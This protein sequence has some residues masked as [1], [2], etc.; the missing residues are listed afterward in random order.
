MEINL[1]VTPLSTL[2]CDPSSCEVD[3]D[4]IFKKLGVVHPEPAIPMDMLLP[5]SDELDRPE[6]SERLAQRFGDPTRMGPTGTSSRIHHWLTSKHAP[7][8]ASPPSIDSCPGGPPP[9]C[10]AAHRTPHIVVRPRRLLPHEEAGIFTDDADA[11]VPPAPPTLRAP[12]TSR[13]VESVLDTATVAV[14]VSTGEAFSL[15]AADDVC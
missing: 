11:V 13:T 12:P 4:A 5:N 15:L 9:S 14:D 6:L 2:M 1:R 10:P 8:D 3:D 7:L